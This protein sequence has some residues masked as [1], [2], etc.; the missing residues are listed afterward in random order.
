MN[1]AMSRDMGYG[2]LTGDMMK[3]EGAVP[4]DSAPAE[5]A[6]SSME[7]TAANNGDYSQ[8]NLQEVGVDEGDIVK[9]DGNYI[10]ALY[11]ST[12]RIIKAEGENL[13]KIS[14]ISLPE[15]D[16]EVHEMYLD[17]NVL[18]LIA[19]GNEASIDE[20]EEDVYFIDR[21]SYT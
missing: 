11:G 13:E 14:E 6:E 2:A 4:M 15:R 19:T 17:G 3:E 7:S 10:Y 9:T 20:Q 12:V 1:Q 5:D 21:K 18:N 16:E 8:T